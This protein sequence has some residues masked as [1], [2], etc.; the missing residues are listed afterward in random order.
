MV[1]QTRILIEAGQADLSRARHLMEAYPSQVPFALAK[2]LTGVARYRVKPAIEAEILRVFDRPTPYVQRSL[3][4]R[5]ATKTK[6]QAEVLFKDETFKGTP[7]TEYLRP[8]VFGGE[9]VLKRSESHLQRVGLQ[10]GEYTVPGDSIPRD[11][12]GNIRRGTITRILSNVG[13][14]LDSAQNTTDKSKARYFVATIKGV[15]GVWE[16][17]GRV[18][19]QVRPALLFVRAPTYKKRLRFYEIGREIT[20]GHLP[21][22][23][24]SNLEDAIAD[25][26]QSP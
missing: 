9:R 25:A 10:P 17:Y 19:R 12:Y 2:A 5:P 3:R 6:L 21:E 26:R 1:D 20:R 15:S 18:A 4:V 14:Q 13:R 11:Q 23:F 8:H 22:D 7:A 16:R 24:F